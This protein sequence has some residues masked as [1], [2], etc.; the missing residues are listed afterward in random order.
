MYENTA[1][2]YQQ[3]QVTTMTPGEV[4]LALYDGMIRFL[5]SA[6]LCLQNKQMTKAREFLSKT[7][8]ILSELTIALDHTVAPELCAQLASIYGF[9]MERAVHASVHAQAQD[10]DEILRT[11]TPLKEAWSV[12]VPDALRAQKRQP[13]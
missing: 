10:I 9:C 6:K 5:N 7:H 12:A 8:A 3:V 1:R 13:P 4:L 2:R 11:L